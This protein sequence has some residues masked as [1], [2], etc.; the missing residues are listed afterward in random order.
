MCWRCRFH[1]PAT[2]EIISCLLRKFIS[3]EVS[4]T[5]I[6]LFANLRVFLVGLGNW[7]EFLSFFIEVIEQIWRRRICWGKQEL[8]RTYKRKSLR[9]L[10]LAVIRYP[11]ALCG[12]SFYRSLELKHTNYW[13]TKLV[14]PYDFSFVFRIALSQTV[15][16][17]V[18]FKALFASFMPR[19][20]V[21]N[22]T[23]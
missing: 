9:V 11:N 5:G 17:T 22:V 14:F 4:V 10:K 12:F 21:E 3:P 7:S 13:A 2:W 18:N 16:V 23:D 15:W 20:I 19:H 8:A 6:N 1:L